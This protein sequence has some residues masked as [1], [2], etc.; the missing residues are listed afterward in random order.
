MLKDDVTDSQKE[1]LEKK[2]DEFE[3]IR[4]RTEYSKEDYAA[5]IGATSTDLHDAYVIS[6][7][8]HDYIGD[9]VDELSALDGVFS[10]EQETAKSNVQLYQLKSFGK[11]TFTDSDEATEE[12]LETGKYKIKKGVITFTPKDSKGS[13]KLLYTKNDLL[14][15][16]ADCTKI[17]AKSDSKC[18]SDN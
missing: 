6:F 16:D 12:E 10:A 2:I 5:Q 17:F 1:V 3:N 15:I 7:D 14:C 13:T 18:G 11:Y 4:N 8:S 9:Y